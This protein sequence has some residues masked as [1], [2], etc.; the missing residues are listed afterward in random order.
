MRRQYTKWIFKIYCIL[1]GAK[2]NAEKLSKIGGVDC[3]RL[4]RAGRAGFVILNR[5]AKECL[6]EKISE[7]RSE[8]GDQVT[9]KVFQK[10]VQKP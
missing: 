5:V 1:D 2:Y 3:A 10:K 4:S 6:T 9:R 8:G 7:Q